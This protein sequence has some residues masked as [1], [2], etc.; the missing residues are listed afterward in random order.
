MATYY[1][2]KVSG[3]L[4]YRQDNWPDASN[5]TVPSP[6]DLNQLFFDCNINATIVLDSIEYSGTDLD[7]TDGVDI[8]RAGQTIRGPISTDPDYANRAGVPVINGAGLA[9]N[10]LVNNAIGTI[11]GEIEIGWAD[12]NYYN[13]ASIAQITLN[14]TILR[15]GWAGFQITGGAAIFNQVDIDETS[16]FVGDVN[17]VG[18][19]LTANLCKYTKKSGGVR[20]LKG[21]YT[22][23][24]CLSDD[25]G[26][27]SV[28]VSGDFSQQVTLNNSIHIGPQSNTGLHTLVNTSANATC[29]ANNCL[30]GGNPY[31]PTKQSSGFTLNDCVL[32]RSPNFV[33]RK[34]RGYIPIV[35]DDTASKDT[36]AALVELADTYGF[37]LVWAVSTT[38]MTETDWQNARAY[39]ANGHEI[40][41]HT[42]SHTHA[43]ATESSNIQYV[44]AGSACTMTVSGGIL[45]TSVTDG[46][47]GENLNID[48]SLYTFLTLSELIDA[49]AA[50]TC[51]PASVYDHDSRAI[52][53]DDVTG[54]DIKTAEY[55]AGIETVGYMEYEIAGSKTDIEANIPG[56]TCTTFFPP[57]GTTSEAV[58]Q[59]AFD[60]GYI[61]AR[62]SQ[63]G[64]RDLSDIE[65]F[66]I[67]GTQIG[68][69]FGLAATAP[70]ELQIKRTA[71]ALADSVE[72]KGYIYSL[73]GHSLDDLDTD[74]SA[75]NWGFVFEALAQ[76]KAPVMTFSAA[77]ADIITNAGSTTG[78]GG[79]LHY[80]CTEE[81]LGDVSDH[82]LQPG[83]PCIDAGIS[84][85]FLTD[86][87]ELPVYKSPDIGP[88]EYQ[89][90]TGRS[91]ITTPGP[92]RRDASIQSGTSLDDAVIKAPL[93]QE[94][95]AIAEWTN[96]ASVDLATFSPTA[97]TRVGLKR[98]LIYGTDLTAAEQNEADRYC[99]A[100]NI[101]TLDADG[102][103]ILDVDNAGIYEES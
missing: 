51:S 36:F 70:T 95:Q 38:A 92:L 97:R 15:G 31:G 12:T 83:S 52:Y 16:A 73:L 39:V 48:L 64:S 20:V 49:T 78:S 46:P 33:S 96:N 56:Y 1:V 53:I 66:A 68:A 29:V 19:S 42:R 85:G 88:H 81:Q 69:A 43:D 91:P 34:R 5:G 28:A 55:T 77:I 67:F 9:D 84:V 17:G 13:L 22:E 98:V 63:L 82:H 102:A 41:S 100:T 65:A 57:Y 74:Y 80:I 2:S 7:A 30:V 26:K 6:A 59:A 24:R 23:N 18:A 71:A 94:F 76:A 101:Y 75:T 58:K 99:G 35:V 3:T 32:D 14:K 72:T 21:D 90:S 103:G 62:I 79:T 40:G 44:G 25:T 11:L 45:T 47:E 27:E 50:Y 37:K 93:S 86:I 87:E 60:A 61:G 4:K 8:G 54:V 89:Y 10:V